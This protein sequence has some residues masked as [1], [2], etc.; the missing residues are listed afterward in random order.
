[1]VGL[2]AV[3]PGFCRLAVAG[4]G[5]KLN[6]PASSVRSSFGSLLQLVVG[7]Y[8][9]PVLRAS[10]QEQAHRGGNVAPAV[11]VTA[12]SGSPGRV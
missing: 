6:Q 9:Q 12:C 1:M 8:G 4:S 7:D 2:P 5:L 10:A 11:C 3:A